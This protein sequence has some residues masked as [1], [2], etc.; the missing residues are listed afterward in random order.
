MVVDRD[1]TFWRVIY[2][3]AW[4]QA[5]SW[6]SYSTLADMEA[7][8]RRWSLNAAEYPEAWGRHGYP[9]PQQTTTIEGTV[10]HFSLQKLMGAL[11]R[12]GC[13][14]LAHESAIVTL[15]G[16]GGFTAIVLNTLEQTLQAYNG[17]PR[18]EPVLDDIRRRLMA[19]VPELRS[20]VQKL[21]TRIHLEVSSGTSA[22]IANELK[23]NSRRPLSQ[24]SYAEVAFR[25]SELRWRGIADLLTLSNTH[26][27]IRDFKTGAPGE[28]H[29]LQLRIYALLWARDS[30]INPSGR[31]ADRLVISYEEGDMEVLAP[32]EVELC[33]LEDELRMRT[34][35]ALSDLQA[36][37][38]EAHPSHENCMYCPVRHLCDEYWPWYAREGSNDNSGFGDVQIRLIGQHGPSSWDGVVECGPHLEGGAPVLFRTGSGLLDLHTG[39]RLRLLNG[40]I[41]MPIDEEYTEDKHPLIVSTT[42]SRSEIFLLSI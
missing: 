2:P 7:C 39:Q 35:R 10:V 1:K 12:S 4:P 20:R 38:P 33:S 30:D 24:G 32:S 17:H 16:L 37:P 31:L 41:N 19:R 27:E 14:S 15:K 11:V 26:C 8:P 28:E 6:M 42:G 34:A 29:K 21:L 5:P 23:N 25:S 9:R 3:S 40:F 22:K 13:P 18:T 36:V